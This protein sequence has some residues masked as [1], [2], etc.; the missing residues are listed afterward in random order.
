V[1]GLLLV[2]LCIF[3]SEIRSRP[4]AV[5]VLLGITILLWSV[6]LAAIIPPAEIVCGCISLAL[7]VVIT[8]TIVIVALK[9]PPMNEKGF[10]FFSIL[11]CVFA[12]MAT[13]LKMC[14][15]F[16]HQTVIFILTAIFYVSF[17]LF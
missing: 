4:V 2:V 9:L 1:L 16:L 13:V 14:D 11:A 7:T 6:G 3:V 15:A 12:V 17:I 10:I 5:Y 8:I